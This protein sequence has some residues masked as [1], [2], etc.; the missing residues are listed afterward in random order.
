MKTRLLSTVACNCLLMIGT[1]SAGEVT[2]KPLRLT[3][4]GTAEKPAVFDG[5]GMVIDLGIDV[6]DHAWK[7]EGDLWTSTSL[8]A[9]AEPM[10][11]GQFT[12][13]FVDEVP[14]TIAREGEG[15]RAI[16]Y[17]KGYRYQTPAGLMPGQMGCTAEGLIYFRWPKDKVPGQARIFVPPKAGTSGVTIACSHIIVRN[18]TAKHASNDGFNVRGEWVGIRLENVRALSNA[19]E[20][21]SAHEEVQMDVEGAEIAWNGSFDAGVADVG[22]STTTYK[23]CRVHD[24]VGA[25]FKFFGRSHSVTDIVIY[26]QAKDF[27]VAEGTK[28]VQE[29]VERR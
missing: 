2:T 24:N 19:D 25:A 11:G 28:F 21:I 8:L 13:L 23:N 4:G 5:K 15:L 17:A 12:G 10:A 14:I 9:G 20:G 27:T 22:H 6:T 26:N 3:E 7:K 16:P 1:V 18:I 29:R